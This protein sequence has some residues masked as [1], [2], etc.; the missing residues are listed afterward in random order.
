MC[1]D[2]DWQRRAIFLFCSQSYMF[3]WSNNDTKDRVGA[4]KNRI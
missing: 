1:K 3:F 4:A 2:L